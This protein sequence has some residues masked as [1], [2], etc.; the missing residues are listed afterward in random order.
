M[1]PRRSWNKVAADPKH[2]SLRE[3]VEQ[4]VEVALD[5]ASSGTPRRMTTQLHRMRMLQHLN[6]QHGGR[7]LVH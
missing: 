7:L 6:R 5:Q 2:T 3:I 4:I 1:E